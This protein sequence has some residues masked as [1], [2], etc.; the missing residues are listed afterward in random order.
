MWITN[1]TRAKSSAK[2][3]ALLGE[4]TITGYA[5]GETGP[6]PSH[7]ILALIAGAVA[8]FAITF[9]LFRTGIIVG[10]LI[11]YA[12]KFYVN[13]PRGIAIAD[14]GVALL[15]RG[16]WTVQPNQLLAKLPHDAANNVVQQSG[17]RVLVDFGIEKV[18]VTKKEYA[19]LQAAA[20]P[21]F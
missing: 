17:S 2:A 13:P 12:I 6:N 18:W 10:A 16:Y 14:R 19:H 9:A 8:I 5:F 3:Q 11:V 1:R 21:R 7:T 20:A 15:K 4:G